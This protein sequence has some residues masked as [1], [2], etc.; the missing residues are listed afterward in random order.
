[1]LEDHR[2]SPFGSEMG[3][4]RQWRQGETGVELQA[5]REGDGKGQAGGFICEDPADGGQEDAALVVCELAGLCLDFIGVVRAF[6]HAK[7][8]RTVRVDSPEEDHQDGMRRRLKKAMYGTRDAAQSWEL[9]YSEMMIEAG[10][11][12]GS[13]SAC[14]PYHKEKDARAVVRGDDFKVL[15]SRSGLD[16]FRE[17]IQR[18][19]EVKGKARLE[20]RRPGAAR[21]LNRIATATSGGV[22]YEADRRHSEIL[23]KDMGTDEGSKAVTTPGS[24]GE[25]GER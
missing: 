9:E 6:F 3:G 13:H 7:A 24:N 2:E 10:C 23:M 8:R 17:V 25:V 19:M 22:D 1:M 4:H 11:K 20:R 16:R 15:G 12:Q 21:I 18:R 14:A 5:S